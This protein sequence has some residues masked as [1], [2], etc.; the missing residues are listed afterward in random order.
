MTNKQRDIILLEQAY[1]SINEGIWSRLKG[2]GAGIAAGLQ[3]GAQN[4]ATS[5]AG[6]LGATVTPSGKTM[7][8]AYANSQQKSI[9][10]SFVA[11]AKKEIEDFKADIVKLGKVEK[12]ED[13]KST[14]PE[15]EQA[16]KACNELLS[17]ISGQASNKNNI[18]VKPTTAKKVTTK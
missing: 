9:F 18:V 16:I 6:K 1:E 11:N 14:H 15:I 7:G 3:Q 12:I 8:K 2:Q 4:V 10:A 5:I 13:L 17:Y